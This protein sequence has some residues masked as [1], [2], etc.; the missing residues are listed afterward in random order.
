M[1][2][3]KINLSALLLILLFICSNPFRANAQTTPDPGLAGPYSVLSMEYDLGDLAFSDPSFPNPME[4]RGSVHYPSTLSA[5]PFPVL[6]LMHGRHET[7]Y[8]TSDPTNTA[9]EWPPS[10]GFQ[11]IT[12][13][14]GYDYFA[15]QMASH[16]YIV[17]S[18]STNAINAADNSVGDY[19]MSARGRL[20][21][22]HL[23]LWNTWN[24]VGG[25]PF[26]TMFVGK[27]DMNNIGTMGHSR[28]GEGVV[29]NALYNKSLGSPY[30]IKAV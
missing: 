21:Q 28:G 6:M 15:T 22:H 3:K 25:S 8:Q 12:S 20:M 10:A 26:G 11:S 4:V 27:L 1:S 19:G 23:D 9:L 16:G 24:T 5:G 2:T 18:I 7:T 30:G 17:I 13:F 14:Q 29:S